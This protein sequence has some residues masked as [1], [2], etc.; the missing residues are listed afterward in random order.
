MC[1]PLALRL[2]PNPSQPSSNPSSAPTFSSAQPTFTPP[3]APTKDKEKEQP[4]LTEVV[5]VEIDE[6]IKV[7]PLM[8]KKKEK[9][10]EKK[11][12]K[13]KEASA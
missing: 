3:A 13:E 2:A 1:Y 12:G 11:R 7:A 8:R 5:E 9:K 4:P 6:A 10:Q